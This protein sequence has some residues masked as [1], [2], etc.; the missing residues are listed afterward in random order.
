MSIILALGIVTTINVKA[1][2]TPSLDDQLNQSKTQYNQSQNSVNEAHK[3]VEDLEIKIE[4][5]DNDI[6]NKMAEIDNTNKKISETEDNIS[7]AQK[8]IDK[9]EQDIRLE[10]ELYNK[11]MRAMYISGNSDYINILLDSKGISDFIS[12]METIKSVA[13]F[14][15]KVI[16]NLSARRQA[17]QEKKDKLQIDKDKLVSL[18][19]D[20]QNDLNDLN[21]KKAEQQ[22]LIAEAKAQEAAAI[23]ASADLKSQIDVINQQIASAKAAEE[24]AKKA[25]EAAAQASQSR[26][27]TASASTSGSVSINRGGSLP[28]S[29]V[30]GSSVV[31]YASNFLGTPYVWGG[32]TPSPGFDC[33]GFMQYVY[34][35]FGVSIGRTTYDQI[36][37]GVAVSR[38]QLQPGDL[39]FFGTSSDPHHVGMY[40]GGGMYIHAPRTGDVIKIS[41]LTRSDYL[42]ARR[43][44]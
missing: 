43:V 37:D 23:Q 12:K 32:T 30:A 38:D 7:K 44:K 16:S 6:Q 11:R 41:P 21:N 8:S 17:I 27:V 13:K 18:K 2:A 25:A 40:V 4:M 10:K 34:S 35:K 14:N 31:S 33:S 15:D 26:N 24:A 1:L 5:L 19:N 20:K 28:A 9:S 22:P 42:T 3:K 29:P 36:N 39:V